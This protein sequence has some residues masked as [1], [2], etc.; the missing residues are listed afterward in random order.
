MNP[1]Q[2]LSSDLASVTSDLVKVDNAGLPTGELEDR[3]A[4]L[5]LE[6]VELNPDLTP[7][8]KAGVKKEIERFGIGKVIK[9]LGKLYNP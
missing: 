7:F 9:D 1:L 6:L 3:A 4:G 2:K 8:D 5:I